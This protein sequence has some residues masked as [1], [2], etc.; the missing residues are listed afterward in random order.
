MQKNTEGHVISPK[1]RND[2]MWN[3]ICFEEEDTCA[4]KKVHEIILTF[5]G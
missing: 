2:K 3:T 5:L 4:K 1:K